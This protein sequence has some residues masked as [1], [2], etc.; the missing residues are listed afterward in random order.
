M[1]LRTEEQEVWPVQEIDAIETNRQAAITQ[2]KEYIRKVVAQY[3][4]RK[5]NA[6]TIAFG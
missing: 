6:P 5:V 2:C 4:P 1:P 3:F